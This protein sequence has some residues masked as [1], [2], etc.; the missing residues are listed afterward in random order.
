MD[1]HSTR[2][3]VADRG[4]G[5]SREALESALLPLYTTKEKGWGIGLTICREIVDAHGGSLC[6]A[7]RDG[8]GAV[9]T[10]V[11]PGEKPLDTMVLRSRTRLTL[12]R[13]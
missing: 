1:G 13:T 12:S 9:V 6:L 7:N 5:L 4:R 11:L 8:G 10:V 3:E 2:F